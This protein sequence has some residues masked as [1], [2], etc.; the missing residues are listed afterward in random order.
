MTKTNANLKAVMCAAERVSLAIMVDPVARELYGVADPVLDEFVTLRRVALFYRGTG[1]Y[2]MTQ[3]ES[4]AALE[5][6]RARAAS[7]T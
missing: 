4:S 6:I 7:V 5:V 1:R 3:E 2:V